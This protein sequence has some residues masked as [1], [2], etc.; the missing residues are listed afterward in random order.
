MHRLQRL[1]SPLGEVVPLQGVAILLLIDDQLDD[2]S[3]IPRRLI[4]GLPLT[5][6]TFKKGTLHH[7]ESILLLFNEDRDLRVVV[8]RLP[9]PTWSSHDSILEQ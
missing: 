5:T 4:H 1:L 9:G 2:L 8:L 3:N 6:A 7:V